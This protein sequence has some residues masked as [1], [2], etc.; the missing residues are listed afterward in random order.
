MRKQ[1]VVITK[2][3]VQVRAIMERSDFSTDI[4]TADEM[5]DFALEVLHERFPTIR[6]D[7]WDPIY[8]LRTAPA[9]YRSWGMVDYQLTA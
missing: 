2:N 4:P 5:Q 7:D 3:R 6:T 1:I 9:S 8:Q